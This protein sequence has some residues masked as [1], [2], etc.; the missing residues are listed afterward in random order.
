MTEEKN[1]TIDALIE[2]SH[3]IDSGTNLISLLALIKE[4]AARLGGADRASIFILDRAENRLWSLLADGEQMIQVPR[5]KGIVGKVIDTN[6]VLNVPDAG[7]DDRFYDYVDKKTGY[8]TRSVLCVP[9]RNREG[10]ALGAIELLNKKDGVFG[11]DDEQIVGILGTQAGLAIENVEMY[12]DIE[13]NLT[14][15]RLLHDIQ[16]NINVSMGVD[17]ILRAILSALLP[18][19]E[20]DCGVI[21]IR[22]DKGREAYYGY[23]LDEGSVCW[24]PG[25]ARECPGFV[26]GIVAQVRE[27]LASTPEKDC[28]DA[29]PVVY[30]QLKGDDEELGYIAVHVGRRESRLF[31]GP[32]LDYLRVV[33]GQTVSLIQKS[34]AL[35]ES[36]RSEK[37][38]LLGT[39][40][41][42][43]IHD[44]KNPLSGV[45]GFVQLI[46]QNP[47]NDSV[48]QY[49]DTI[50]ES[51]ARL[52][53]MNSELLAFVRG[54]SIVLHKKPVDLQTLFATI[55]DNSREMLRRGGVD[56]GIECDGEVR[57]SA[58]EDRLVR[59]FGNIL[60]NA[61]ESMADG[62]T[63]TVSIQR[64]GTTAI[65]KIADTGIGMPAH[66]QEKIFE[67]FVTHGKK[68][69]TGLGMAIARS[70]IEEHGG[71]IVVDSMLGRGTTFTISLMLED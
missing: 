58:D 2:V 31:N 64:D 69:G 35:E 51:L 67:P 42:S 62:G 45:S 59:A 25:E 68:N 50:L 5:G 9:M 3:A 4:I 32:P 52:E 56:F 38:A 44:M 70:I 37:Q 47:H 8:K 10:L 24:E 22:Y 1:S 26:A 17:R 36:K 57:V 66:L 29:G 41:S 7:N 21:H 34:R 16:N 28:F 65:V 39:M 61:R 71:N 27:A 46:R 55:R 19:I 14:Q 40:L 49:C 63:L 33:A 6:Q 53:R 15:F 43:V 30:A 12:D 54:D 48:P 18:V 20:G 23:H 13:R 11:R 60:N